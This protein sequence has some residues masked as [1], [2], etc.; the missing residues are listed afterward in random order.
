[1]ELKDIQCGKEYIFDPQNHYRQNELGFVKAIVRS[2]P[3]N[4]F[5]NRFM[6]RGIQVNLYGDTKFESTSGYSD[7]LYEV[8]PEDLEEMKD[9][10]IIIR[11]PENAPVFSH[12]DKDVFAKIANMVVKDSE[13]ATRFDSNEIVQMLALLSKIS[14]YSDLH[15]DGM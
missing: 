10:N 3:S 13:I 4:T 7:K 8:Q 11:Y 12:K 9:K 2:V 15:D 14:F 5:W 6:R 1:M